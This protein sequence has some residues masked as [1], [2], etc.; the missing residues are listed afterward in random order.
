MAQR[1][2]MQSLK[3]LLRERDAA[4]QT[5]MELIAMVECLIEKLLDTRLVMAEAEVARARNLLA[6][7]KSGGKFK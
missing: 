7:I 1:K 4:S 2:R 6:R 5:A 3:E